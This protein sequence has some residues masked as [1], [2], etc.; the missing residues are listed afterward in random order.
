MA[1]GQVAGGMAAI[2][3]PVPASVKRLVFVCHGNI[4]RSAYADALARAA[5]FNVASFGLSTSTGNP[6]WPLVAERAAARGLDLT[7]H[8]ATAL[9]DFVP[10]PGDYLLG[11]EVRHLHKLAVDPRLGHL[12][13][14]LLGQ[15]A[16]PRIPHLH[17]PYQLNPAYM[18][19]CLERVASAV[20]G[21]LSAYP[22]ARTA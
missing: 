21:L 19:V 14:G 17:D 1:Y 11:M 22:A 3:A 9:A 18:E 8:R 10:Q 4:C 13:R 20:A 16:R 6:A 2:R 15:Y 12:P 5:G 7:A